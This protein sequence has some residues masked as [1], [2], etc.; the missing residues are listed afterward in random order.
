ML[1]VY[2]LAKQNMQLSFKNITNHGQ[3]IA[4]YFCIP[5]LH[6]FVVLCSWLCSHH[7]WKKILEIYIWKVIGYNISL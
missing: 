7:T 6:R 1:F 3:S 4:D 5:I 2:M